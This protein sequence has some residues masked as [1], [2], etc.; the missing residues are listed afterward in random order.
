MISN[1]NPEGERPPAFMATHHRA[2]IRRTENRSTSSVSVPTERGE[3][4]HTFVF[5]RATLIVTE[6]MYESGSWSILTKR[7]REKD[8]PAS[9]RILHYRSTT[10]VLPLPIRLSCVPIPIFR[11]AFWRNGRRESRADNDWLD[12]RNHIPPPLDPYYPT[13]VPPHSAAVPWSCLA[14]IHTALLQT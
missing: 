3:A 2:V 4:H 8:D 10:R 13:T 1:R 9:F 14:V 6:E 11:L 7:K 5:L 12:N